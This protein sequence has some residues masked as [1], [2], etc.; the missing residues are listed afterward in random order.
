MP[1]RIELRR[2]AGRIGPTTGPWIRRKHI[3]RVQGLETADA[4]AEVVNRKGETLGWGVLSPESSIAVRVL[5]FGQ[6]PP[7]DDWL[8][9]RLAASVDARD[10]YGFATHETTGYRV[11]NS[12]GDGLPGLV[13]DRYDEDFVLQITTAPMATRRSAIEAW[14]RERG[15]E[16]LHVVLPEGAAKHEG[17]EPGVFRQHDAETLR[18]REYGVSFETPAP[19]SQK[20]GAYFDQRENR[21][22]VAQLAAAHGGRLLDVGCHIGGFALHAARAGIA[23]VGVDSSAVALEHA[24]KNT[25]TNSLPDLSWIQ[26]DMFGPL[27]A[28]E[29]EGPFGTIVLDPPKVATSKN[30]VDKAV[31]A[32]RRLVGRVAPRLAPGGHLVLCSCSHHLGRDHLDRVMATSRGSWTRVGMLGAGPD[33]P[34]APGHREGEYLRVG[35]YRR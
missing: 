27:D 35:V 13:V 11:V 32:M 8:Q 18:F 5:T 15:H 7:D 33:H 6:A 16:R 10:H 26:A 31:D 21:R 14:F 29:L 19:P 4:I 28:T 1:V 20:T 12:E 23:A 25:A 9:T 30:N 24:A 2:D 17:F 34:V 22:W 3:A